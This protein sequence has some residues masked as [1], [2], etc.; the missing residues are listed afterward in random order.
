MLF[1]YLEREHSE[2]QFLANGELANEMGIRSEGNSL[3]G[4]RQPDSSGERGINFVRED[5]AS[6]LLRIIQNHRNRKKSELK[7]QSDNGCD[8]IHM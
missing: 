1:S 3:L 7:Q 4:E 8:N 2:M 6:I 5:L